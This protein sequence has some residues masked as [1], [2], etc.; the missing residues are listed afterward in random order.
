MLCFR[1]SH[2]RYLII[3]L[4]VSLGFL[5]VAYAQ[6]IDNLSS[7]RNIQSTNYFRFHYDND[8]FTASDKNYTQGYSFEL[9]APFF[10]KNPLNYLFIKPADSETRFGLATEHIGYT[11]ENYASTEIQEG[12]RPFAAAIMLKSFMIATNVE[13]QSRL[14][15]SLS[16]GIIGPGAFGK[17]M[18]VGIHEITGNKIPMGWRY[19]IKNDAALNYEVA[20]EKQLLRLYDIASLQASAHL[21]A[22]T[23]FTNGSLGLNATVG[24]LDRPF[25]SLNEG[26]GFALFAYVQ[27]LVSVVG[28]DATLQG[29]FF[30]RESPYTINS[31]D[32]ERVTTQGTIGIV[33]KTRTLYVEYARSFIS[34]EFT[35]GNSYKWGGIRIGFT[36]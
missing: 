29:G 27:P 19:Q 15:S 17:E 3:V 28:Y 31:S 33:L 34:R 21:K 16:L 23:L 12:D 4:A 1:T 7:F 32:I 9:V 25:G 26:H 18:Q 24:L 30:N 5:Q 22:G 13:H 20:Y 10:S 14:T 11:P 6:K 35:T 8:Y 2:M 36:L